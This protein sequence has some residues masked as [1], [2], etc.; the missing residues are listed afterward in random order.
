M[1]RFIYLALAAALFIG[2]G[3]EADTTTDTANADA[4]ATDAA[5][6]ATA[7]A[8][9]EAE[10]APA[11]CPATAAGQLC[12]TVNVP[13]DAPGVPVQVS[14][15]FFNSLPPL[16]PPNQ[17]GAEINANTNPELLAQFTPGAAVE[18]LLKDLPET[19]EMYLY[20]VLYMEGGGA[21]T[22]QSVPDVDF[23]GAYSYDEPVQFAGESINL[24][25]AI[26]VEIVTED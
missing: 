25:N 1:S 2:C 11:T 4:A 19:G 14:V 20:A 22:W 13:E 26:T 21:A 12:V 10:A 5:A 9:A 15:H 16:G 17:M 8:A 23:H 7:D 24:D 3:D 6:D 18:L